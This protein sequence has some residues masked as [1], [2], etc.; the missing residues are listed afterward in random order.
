MHQSCREYSLHYASSIFISIYSSTVCGKRTNRF[1]H[2]PYLSTG[3]WLLTAESQMEGKGEISQYCQYWSRTSIVIPPSSSYLLTLSSV[4]G[5]RRAICVEE[6]QHGPKKMVVDL[7]FL[8]FISFVYEDTGMVSP[9]QG[10][11]VLELYSRASTQTS[12]RYPW[13]HLQSTACTWAPRYQDYIKV[14]DIFHACDVSRHIR[15]SKTKYVS[16]FPGW[17]WL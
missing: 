2:R 7:D 9:R 16:A 3:T 11:R 4:V 6:W 14:K 1:L 15:A 5:K 17:M 10:R 12:K 8:W 13:K